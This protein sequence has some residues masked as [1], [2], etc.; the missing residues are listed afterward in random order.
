M[1]SIKII[2][3]LQ[4][5]WDKSRA[6]LDLI[7]LEYNFFF[8]WFDNAKKKNLEVLFISD[9]TV[10]SFISNKFTREKRVGA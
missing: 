9:G 5:L 2:K 3:K 1:S 7:Q 6:I 4:N 10:V 8:V